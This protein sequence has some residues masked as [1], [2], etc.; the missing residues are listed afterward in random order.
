MNIAQMYISLQDNTNAPKT[1]ITVTI[2]PAFPLIAQG[3]SASLF[4]GVGPN[5]G[6][7]GPGAASSIIQPNQI[8]IQG[9]FEQAFVEVNVDATNGVK[10]TISVNP[11]IPVPITIGA[12]FGANLY[13][14]PANTASGEFSLQFSGQS[15]ATPPASSIQARAAVAMGQ[16]S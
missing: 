3:G 11:P 10:G 2:Q 15:S 12:L 7:R 16:S 5:N 14:L 8:L 1:E 6:N 9:G 4:Y 13:T